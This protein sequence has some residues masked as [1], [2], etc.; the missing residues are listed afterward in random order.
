MAFLYSIKMPTLQCFDLS[1]IIG[2]GIKQHGTKCHHDR[3]FCPKS[4]AGQ[5]DRVQGFGDS[6]VRVAEKVRK[7]KRERVLRCKNAEFSRAKDP[8]PTAKS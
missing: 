7:C 2:F 3:A 1:K 6:R 8:L 5:K 4:V